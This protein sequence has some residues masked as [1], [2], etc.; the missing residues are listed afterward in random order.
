MNTLA[1]LLQPT[2]EQ[3]LYT[4]PV[5]EREISFG[6]ESGPWDP[7]RF[8][9]EQIRSLVSQV[10]LP[11]WPKPARQV[12]FSAVDHDTDVVGICMQ[13]GKALS[14]QVSGSV[15]VVQSNFEWGAEEGLQKERPRPGLRDDK[16][17]SVRNSSQRMSNNLWLVPSDIFAEGNG[18]GFATQPLSGRVA[19]LRLDFDYAVLCGPPAGKCSQAALLGHLCDGVILVLE[20]NS[21]RRV[22]AQKAKESLYAANARLLGVVL[23]QRSFPIPDGIY[24]KL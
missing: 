9:E 20:A 1:D 6:Q 17:G 18:S 24:R 21:T 22:A 12:V 16:F 13:V 14:D 8:G 2:R 15:C 23:S 19:E 7:I 4:S 10:F 11:G 5:G 3:D